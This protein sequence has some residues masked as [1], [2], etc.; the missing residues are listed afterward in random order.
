MKRALPVV[1]VLVAAFAL[2]AVSGCGGGFRLRP[3]VASRQVVIASFQ[4][5]YGP[6]IQ[7][8]RARVLDAYAVPLHMSNALRQSYPAGPGPAVQVTITQFRVGRYGPS[9]MHADVQVL[10]PNNAVLT[11]FGADSTTTR[12]GSRGQI[13][14][15]LSQDITN[16]IAQRL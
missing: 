4:V 9:R 3:P 8:D 13:T 15:A 14:E 12:G 1:V 5:H 6:R 7:G 10:G 11:Q 2:S 16:Q